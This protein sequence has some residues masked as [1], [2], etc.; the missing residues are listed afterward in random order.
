M[1]STIKYFSFFFCIFFSQ[2]SYSQHPVCEFGGASDVDA[3]GWGFENNQS[4]IVEDP[5]FT[6]SLT[7]PQIL[8]WADLREMTLSCV[9]ENGLVSSQR[10]GMADTGRSFIYWKFFQRISFPSYWL[11]TWCWFIPCWQPPE[12]RCK[13]WSSCTSRVRCG[14][15]SRDWI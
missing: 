3:D 5:F 6:E 11:R 4:C 9:S 8:T 12:I 15:N 14:C 7:V 10:I 13:R 1:N 2:L